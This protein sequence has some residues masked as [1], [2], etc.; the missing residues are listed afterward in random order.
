VP[1]WHVTGAEQHFRN[2]LRGI[3]GGMKRES[4]SFFETYKLL[5]TAAVGALGGMIFAAAVFVAAMGTDKAWEI[6][7]SSSKPVST[8]VE[9]ALRNKN[10]ELITILEAIG[11]WNPNPHRTADSQSGPGYEDCVGN[12]RK[13]F[14]GTDIQSKTLLLDCTKGCLLQ[15]SAIMKGIYERFYRSETSP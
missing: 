3:E 12:C 10:Q 5:L 13:E 1:P 11:R 8:P 2:C 6:F 7:A 15:Y 9:V 4:E 14:S